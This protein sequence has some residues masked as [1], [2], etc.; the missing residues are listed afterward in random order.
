MISFTHSSSSLFCRGVDPNRLVDQ[1]KKTIDDQLLYRT[2]SW[3]QNSSAFFEAY[4]SITEIYQYLDDLHSI[5]SNI[6][7]VETI[8]ATTEGRPLKLFKIGTKSK[9]NIQKPIIWIDAVDYFNGSRDKESVKRIRG[10][11]I[12]CGEKRDHITHHF[13]GNID[14]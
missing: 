11:R 13:G 6:S 9:D 3:A 2:K 10:H 7:D 5:G 14:N 8:G 4:H 1:E 12:G